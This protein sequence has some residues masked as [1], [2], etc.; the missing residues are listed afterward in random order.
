[1]HGY[2]DTQARRLSIATLSQYLC[3]AVLN[4]SRSPPCHE[5]TP[6][7]GDYHHL[8]PPHLI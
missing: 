8:A 3:L 1:M 5:D 7:P 6:A 2:K 4:V